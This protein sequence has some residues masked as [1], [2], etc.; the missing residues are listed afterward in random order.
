[1]RLILTSLVALGTIAL[2]TGCERK[3]KD[4]TPAVTALASGQTASTGSQ[5]ITV[6]NALPQ[7][8]KVA[9]VTGNLSSMGSD[10]LNNLMAFWVESFCKEY[11]NVRIQVEGKGS[12]TAPPALIEG[13]AQLGPMSR[14]MTSGEIDQFE[15]KFGYKPTKIAVALDTLAVFVHRDNPINELSLPQLDGIYSKTFTSGNRDVKTW[16]DV[17]VKGDLEARPISLYGRNSASG[18]YGYFKEIALFKGDYKDTVK[19]QPG[20]SAVV[21][22]VNSDRFG[23]GYSGIGYLTSGIKA[24]AIS[25]EVNGQAYSATYANAL[26]GDYPL[27]RYLYIFVNRHPQNG[28]SPVVKEFLT[29]VLSKEGQEIVVK[30]GYLPLSAQMS[31]NEVKKL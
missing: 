11:P 15:K 18:T 22:G 10:S 14:D 23:I 3:P 28:L 9:G 24:L 21:Q 2:T 30:D 29:F 12:G 25:K 1:M 4:E 19:E 7:Y 17:G 27:S 26:S 5:P 13:T 6:D 16:G 8:S 20:S 31:S